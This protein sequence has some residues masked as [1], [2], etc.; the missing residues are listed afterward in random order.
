MIKIN[1]RYTHSTLKGTHLLQ[2]EREG[3]GMGGES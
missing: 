2:I 3:K 1:D